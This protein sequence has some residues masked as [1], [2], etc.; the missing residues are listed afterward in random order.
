MTAVQP[1]GCGLDSSLAPGQQSRV[2][3]GHERNLGS[4]CL[5][6]LSAWPLSSTFGFPSG[7]CVTFVH[8]D[9]V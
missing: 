6:F 3:L 5:C 2:E 7:C 1:C 4:A 8:V 9:A